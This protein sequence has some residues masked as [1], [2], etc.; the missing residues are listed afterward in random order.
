MVQRQREVFKKRYFQMLLSS[1]PIL[2]LVVICS[3]RGKYM[4]ARG[5]AGSLAFVVPVK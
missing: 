4:Y 3:P 1:A 5:Y 2:L